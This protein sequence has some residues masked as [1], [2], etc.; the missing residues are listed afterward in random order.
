M[1]VARDRVWWWRARSYV[2]TLLGVP[3]PFHTFAFTFHLQR[4]SG[5]SWS[6]IVLMPNVLLSY[7]A[8]LTCFLPP[9]VGERLGVPP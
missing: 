9:D 7:L 4:V 2:Y 1:V 6:L 8:I 5:H 3:E